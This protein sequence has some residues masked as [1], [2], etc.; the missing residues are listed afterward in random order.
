M[1]IDDNNDNENNTCFLKTIPFPVFFISRQRDLLGSTTSRHLCIKH[2]KLT[3]DVLICC[4]AYV[5][6]GSY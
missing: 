2:A 5:I 6:R 4:M 1:N 3:N